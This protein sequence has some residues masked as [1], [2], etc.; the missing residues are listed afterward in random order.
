MSAA[1]PIYLGRDFYVPAFEVNPPGKRMPS[2]VLH[3]VV[4]VSYRDALDEVDS[5]TI[6]VNNWDSAKQ[7]FKYGGSTTFLPGRPL[8]LWAGYRGKGRLTRLMSGEITA[9]RPSFPGSGRPTLTVTVLNLLHRLRAGQHTEVY[10]NKTDSQIAKQIADRLGVPIRTAPSGEQPYPYQIQDN[11]YDVLFLLRL[12]RRIGYE[13][14]IEPTPGRD[15]GTLRFEPSASAR[16]VALRL[17]WGRSLIEF[18]PTLSTAR[19]VGEVVVLAW[20]RR[21]KKR[22]TARVKRSALGLPRDGEVD[23]SFAKRVETVTAV[24]A[25]E[26]EA[27]RIARDRMRTISA[28]L[29]RATG[30][31]VGLPDLRAG[32]RLAIDGLYGRFNGEYLVTATRH[33]LGGS[34]YHTSFD[35]RKEG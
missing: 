21:R 9:V 6:T 30:S 24:V 28:G 25:S 1:E 19:Q 7:S 33:V 29:V 10:E 16:P 35:C 14:W 8:E 34:G 27:L 22:I 5:C 15:L 17:T 20:D 2:D 23:P 26:Q 4:D 3:D 32:S 18:E 11:E 31:T 13:L 12:A